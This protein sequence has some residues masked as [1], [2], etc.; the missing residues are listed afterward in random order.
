MNPVGPERGAAALEFAV[1]V[2][3][4]GLLIFPLLKADIGLGPTFL[5]LSAVPLI[6]AIICFTIKWEPTMAGVNVDDEPD[7]PG[8]DDAP[9]QVAR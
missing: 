9:V 8:F 2:P 3:A 5:I 1:I 7:A 6:C 4:L